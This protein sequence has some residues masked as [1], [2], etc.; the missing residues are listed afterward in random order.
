MWSAAFTGGKT[1]QVDISDA[2][3][4]LLSAAKV[5][6]RLADYVVDRTVLETTKVGKEIGKFVWPDRRRAVLQ[7]PCCH[8]E[9]KT[10]QGGPMTR[11]LPS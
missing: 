6:N 2:S 1:S 5:L 4:G 3:F 10:V 7:R 8:E 11:T 9:Q